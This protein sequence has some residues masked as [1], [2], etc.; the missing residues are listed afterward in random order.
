M[1]LSHDRFK[2]VNIYYSMYL[3]QKIFEMGDF[4]EYQSWVSII[5]MVDDDC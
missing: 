5:K 4:N 1:L 2:K 3:K